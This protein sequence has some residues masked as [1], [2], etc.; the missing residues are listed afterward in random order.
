MDN[1]SISVADNAGLGITPQSQDLNN[2]IAGDTKSVS[3]SVT[4]PFTSTIGPH[5]VIFQITYFDFMGISHTENMEALVTVAKLST[6]ITLGVEPSSVKI[7]DPCTITANLVDGNGNPIANQ[8][9]S[10]SVGATSIGS[11]NTDS[12][13]NAVQTYTANVV[14]AGT[15]VISATFDGTADYAPSSKTVN[16]IVESGEVAAGE[17]SALELGIIAAVAAIVIIALLILVKRRGV[18][19]PPVGGGEGISTPP[20]PPPT[21]E[22]A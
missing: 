6:S 12:S 14:D 10:F 16:L 8:V 5:P 3:F 19:A 1:V 9:I 18:K 2:I 4:A 21:P 17:S 15:Y 22:D 11:D 7:G 20:T 13:G